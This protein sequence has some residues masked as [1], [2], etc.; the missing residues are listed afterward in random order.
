MFMVFDIETVPDV[1]TGRRWLNLAPSQG[2]E[3]VAEAMLAA[4]PGNPTA[5]FLK[6]AFHQVVAIAAALIDDQG[7]MRRLAALGNPD[8]NEATLVQQF[9]KVVGDLKPRLV[10]W[11][12][13]AFDLPV[14]IYRALYH[15][16]RVPEFYRHGEPYHSYRKRYDEESHLDLMDVLSGYGASTRVSLHE[17]AALLGVPGKMG[18]TGADVWRLWRGGAREAIRAYC[19]S[20]VMTTAIVFAQYAY[21]RGWFDT[22]ALETF[23]ASA[24]AFLTL[25]G[26]GHWAQ[27]RAYWDRLG[28]EDAGA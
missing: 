11:N 26:G 25:S 3:A 13:S 16:L 19:E 23:E 17:I 22:H 8:D 18:T 12:S 5:P 6:P 27:F 24:R 14:L 10:G 1:K 28:E 7:R 2:E 4:S 15:R 9:F 20:D 21:H